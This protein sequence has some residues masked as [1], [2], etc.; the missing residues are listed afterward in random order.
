M[1][2]PCRHSN[3]CMTRRCNSGML[4]GNM[5]A[6]KKAN[7]HFINFIKQFNLN[8]ITRALH[9]KFNSMQKAARRATFVRPAK[10]LLPEV[11]GPTKLLSFI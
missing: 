1:R 4:L 2:T 6:N 7:K 11:Q 5:E 8:S 9:M 10:Q 3:A